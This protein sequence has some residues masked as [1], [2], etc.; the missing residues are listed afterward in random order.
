MLLGFNVGH[1]RCKNNSLLDSSSFYA[2]GGPIF[3]LILQSGVLLFLLIWIEGDIA[4]FRKKSKVVTPGDGEKSVSG[5]SAS[6]DVGAEKQR[7]ENTDA[8]L[9]RLLHLSKAFGSNQAVDDVTLGLPPSEVLALIGPNGAGKST[10]VN[11]IQ[12]DLSADR[13]QAYLCGEDS[14]TRSAQKFLGVCPQY[15]AMD[16]MNTRDHLYFYARIKGI[17]DAKANVEHIMA[18]LGL[19]PHAGTQAMKLSGGNKR[20]LS[21]AIALIGTPPVLVLDEPTSAMDAV[22][23]RSFWKIIQSI[24][25]N[26]SVL[27]TVSFYISYPFYV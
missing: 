5:S 21:L 19:T 24:S 10:L 1:I 26:H 23:K 15:D 12:S 18:R 2:F 4:F 20:K 3:Y 27:L 6:D 9:L 22:A 8:D 13:G 17:D 11:L 25:A 16:M 7:V 14:R